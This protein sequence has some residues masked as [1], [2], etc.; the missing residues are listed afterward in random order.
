MLVGHSCKTSDCLSDG[1]Q[2]KT[3]KICNM[4][5]GDKL[6]VVI[7]GKSQRCCYTVIIHSPHHTSLQPGLFSFVVCY[8]LLRNC[9]HI[10]FIRPNKS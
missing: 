6:N 2:I 1:P 9:T 5:F 8:S 10:Y 4:S 7:I 3:V